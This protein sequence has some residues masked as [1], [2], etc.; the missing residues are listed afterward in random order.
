MCGAGGDY[1]NALLYGSAAAGGGC[2][3]VLAGVLLLGCCNASAEAG[4]LMTVS[5]L[6][7]DMTAC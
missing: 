4:A 2:G 3:G 1:V 7:W 6:L 5:Q